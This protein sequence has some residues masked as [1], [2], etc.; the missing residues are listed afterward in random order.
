MSVK[1]DLHKRRL[2]VKRDVCTSQE[3][4]NR[5]V[6]QAKGEVQRVALKLRLPKK[7][8]S[9]KRDLCK[10][11][12]HVK[13]DLH[14]ICVSVKGPG[15][16]VFSCACNTP[17]TRLQHACN[18]PATRLQHA[19]NTTSKSKETYLQKRPKKHEKRPTQETNKNEKRSTK[20]M[21]VAPEVLS[22]QGN[23]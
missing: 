19:C 3:T 15:A 13:R 23:A 14:Q 18:T 12:M 11:R 1:R 16:T 5:D 22:G 6:N 10:R 20:E 9:V 21:Y 7:P 2:H 4:Y 8:T 17:A